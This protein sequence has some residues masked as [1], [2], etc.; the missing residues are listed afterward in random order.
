MELFGG[1]WFYD[2]MPVE[3]LDVYAPIRVLRIRGEKY[4]FAI[5]YD[6]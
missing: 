6:R 4:L 3:N 1:D 2:R 5:I